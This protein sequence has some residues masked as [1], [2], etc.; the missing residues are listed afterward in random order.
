MS[1]YG[2]P[3]EPPRFRSLLA[4]KS[5]TLQVDDEGGAAAIPNTVVEVWGHV[6]LAS[7]SENYI[8]E[9]L[10]SQTEFVLIVANNPAIKADMTV[11]TRDGRVLE[12]L[13]VLR[14]DTLPRFLR[15]PCRQ[16]REKTDEPGGG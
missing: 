10:R 7:G 16:Y 14:D 8:A 3:T 15:I 4:F 1:R 12:V 9:Q 13:D 5:K 6:G 11:T 2:Y